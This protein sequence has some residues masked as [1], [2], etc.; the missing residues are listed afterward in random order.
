[1]QVAQELEL[2][3]SYLEHPRGLEIGVDQVR[4]GERERESEEMR[5]PTP[6]M[7]EAQTLVAG[8]GGACSLPEVG[9]ACDL[10][11]LEHPR[12]LEI[13]VDQVMSLILLLLLLYSRYKSS[14]VLEP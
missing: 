5:P 4:R 8:E 9:G 12:G 14:K 11:Y 10:S 3:L 7:R 6:N 13:G 1:V 2:L